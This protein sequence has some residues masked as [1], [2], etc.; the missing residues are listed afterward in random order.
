MTLEKVNSVQIHKWARM[1][2]FLQEVQYVD[3]TSHS[4][5]RG[6]E[7]KEGH[8]DPPIGEKVKARNQNVPM[9]IPVVIP[10]GWRTGGNA[11]TCSRPDDLISAC[12][13][14]E[15]AVVSPTA[16]PFGRKPLICLQTNSRASTDGAARNTQM[17]EPRVPDETMQFHLG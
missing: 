8:F 4:I 15:G 5:Y 6:E 3:E 10:V 13:L 7:K 1:V 17:P 14:D 11:N 9:A 12:C 2:S 16:S